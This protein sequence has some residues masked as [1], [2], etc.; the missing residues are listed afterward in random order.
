MNI[1]LG[2]FY[3]NKS[4]SKRGPI[5]A[6]GNKHFPF[7]CGATLQT[8][9]VSGTF[10]T[11]ADSSYD[12]AGEWIEPA[13]DFPDF[14]GGDMQTV[15]LMGHETP[16][17]VDRSPDAADAMAYAFSIRTPLPEVKWSSM[18]PLIEGFPQSVPT[19]KDFAAPG[20]E[21]LAGVLQMAHD[22]AA[23]GKGKERHANGKP[24]DDQPIMVIPAMLGSIEGQM[25]QI[26]KKA[27]EA[28]SMAKR[29]EDDAAISELLG[30]INYAAAAILSL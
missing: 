1:E 12:L 7:K 24:F 2:K 21:E 10:Y 26:I 14:A 4:G 19:F 28:N 11:D 6:S 13:A 3:V 18:E 25:Y 5:I 27:Q 23:T 29:G 17:K 9:T 22:H 20:Y 16:V 8:F 30:V 15:R